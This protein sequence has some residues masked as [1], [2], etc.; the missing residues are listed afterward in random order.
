MSDTNVN[1]EN[2]VT[3]SVVDEN[4]VEPTSKTNV[5]K[6][7]GNVIGGIVGNVVKQKV[8]FVV[9]VESKAIVESMVEALDN[10]SVD[11]LMDVLP[12]LISHVENYK[13]LSGTEK[14]GLVIK[15]LYHIIDITDCPGD[16]EIWDPIVKRLVPSIIDSMIKIEN[17]QIKLRK[18]PK[19]LGRFLSCMA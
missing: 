5:E 16:D 18:K 14:R 4:I 7:V 6:I 19:C 12:R 17:K 1:I 9:D 15:M 2:T 13:N 8:S 11:K 10:F 3:V